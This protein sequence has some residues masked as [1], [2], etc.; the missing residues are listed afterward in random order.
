M[1]LLT[2]ARVDQSARMP[3]GV[4]SRSLPAPAGWERGGLAIPFYGC[5]EPVLRDKCVSAE[6][7]PNRNAAV[8]EFPAVPI[9]QGVTCSTTGPDVLAQNAL[10]R[11]TATSDWAL[12]RQLQTDQADTGAPKLDDVNPIGPIAGADFVA[13]LGCLEQLAADTGFGAVWVVHTT[14]RGMAYLAAQTLVTPDGFTPS[15]ARVI[16]GTGYVNPDSTHVRMWATGQVWASI[17]TPEAIETLGYQTN[18]QDAWAS[19]VGVAAFDPCL[20]VAVDVTV[21]ACPS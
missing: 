2:P 21:P 10:D 15:G 7:V 4:L 14:P 5:G 6:D 19:T 12:S 3:G 17:S 16:V 20:L 13:G 18:D 11:L 9:E 1:V 8:A